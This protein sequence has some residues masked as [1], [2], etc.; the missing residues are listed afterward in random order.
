MPR[1][2]AAVF[3]RDAELAELDAALAGTTSDRHTL[4]VVLGARG[5]GRTALLGV[6]VERWRRRGVVVLSLDFGAV[7]APPWDLF[8][9]GVVITALRE[10][11]E[12][13]GDSSLAEP[14]N[15][16]A[17]LCTA[18]TYDSARDRGRLL[19]RLA[20]AFGRLGTGAAVVVV[21]D[22]LDAV[23]S[24][25]FALAPACLPGFLVVAACQRTTDCT[26]AAV[27]LA[28]AA[29]RRLDLGPLPSECTSALLAQR[30][31]VTADDSL[32]TALRTALGPLAGHPDTLVSTVDTLRARI[33][34]VF[35]RA[36]LSGTAPVALAAGHPLVERVRSFGDAGRDLVVAVATGDLRIDEL[37]VLAAAT[38]RDVTEY[39]RAVDVLVAEGGLA[40]DETGLLACACPALAEA[41]LAEAPRAAE[42]LHRAL[43]EHLL[44][45]NGDRTTIAEHVARAGDQLPRSAALEHLL[46]TEADLATGAGHHDRAT[47]CY[48][49]ALRHSDK[50]EPRVL[51]ATV[52]A[53]LHS[54][55]YRA[56]AAVLDEF[57][58]RLDDLRPALLARAGALVSLHT[59]TPVPAAV[60]DRVARAGDA[61]DH[62]LMRWCDRWLAGDPELRM[63]GL[64]QGFSRGT[65]NRRAE[66]AAAAA[67]VDLAAVVEIRAGYRVPDSG[68]LAHYHRMVSGYTAGRWSAALSSARELALTGTATPAHQLGRLMAAEICVGRD[69]LEQARSWLEADADVRGFVAVRGWVR[70]GFLAA[71]GD[72]EGALAAGWQAYFEAPASGDQ[73]RDR[74]RLLAR[75]AVVAT[76]GGYRSA[77]CAAYVALDG[78][79]QRANDHDTRELFLFTRGLVTEDPASVLASA[80]LARGRG[81]RPALLAA[82][83]VLGELA[84]EPSPWLHEA[85]S[86]AEELA[87]PAAKA[88]ARTLMR[89]RGVSP[90]RGTGD[91]HEL[92]DTE[93]RIVDLVRDGRTNRQIA[94][95]LLISEKTVE[96]NVSRLLGAT[97][98]RSR[99]GLA[100]APPLL[101]RQA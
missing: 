25:A 75:L 98:H 56:L 36:C 39:G 95:T 63:A 31:G 30:I 47:R 50:R 13:T 26:P 21:A 40:C 59:G 35:G 37:P 49:A 6:A 92:S 101:L 32:H 1:E 72:T 14:V 57:S 77:A 86:L 93:R 34:P 17:A 23:P 2:L 5:V 58:A 4:M 66:L 15:A 46:L 52:R 9:A 45:A 60:R 70:S 8:G 85:H 55:Q 27:D 68:P 33:V 73:V 99:V 64:W 83:L 78:L 28:Q 97:G 53:M 51:G 94:A 18:R 10:H 12:R 79:H 76:D 48:L 3:G 71:G 81:H 22:D 87:C 62:E 74:A 19:S 100:T 42:A 44:G 89:V 24:P 29:D 16:A 11:C 7:D 54:G 82:C 43:A 88:R 41:V 96:A 80:R 91:R 69:D 90:P 20:T 61:K 38:G 67:C 65:R 84:D